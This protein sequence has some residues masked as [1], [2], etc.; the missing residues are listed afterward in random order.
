MATHPR[1]DRVEAA[2]HPMA[3]FVSSAEY[4]SLKWGKEEGT[5]NSATSSVV[6]SGK[7]HV[8]FSKLPF[9]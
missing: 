5:L 2:A 9:R 6:F 8:K 4:S 7:N 1:P 3:A